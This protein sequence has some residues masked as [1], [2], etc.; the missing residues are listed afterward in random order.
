MASNNYIY[1]MSNAGGMSTLTRYTDMLAGNTTWNPWEPAGAY[2]SVAVATVPSGGV[3]SITFSSI[4]QTYTH[5][6]IRATTRTNRS[7]ANN[8][9][10]FLQFNGDTASNYSW[11]YL[12][13]DGSNATSGAGATQTSIWT[14]LSASALSSA[15][16]FGAQVIDILDYANISKGKTIRNLG[17]VDLNGTSGGAMNLT[18]GNWRSNSSIT[19]ITLFSGFGSSI[20]QHSSFALYGIKG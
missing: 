12:Q 5:L 10:I 8:D 14:W 4:P 11:H 2:E 16:I 3:A 13:G 20:S 15:N 6:Q 7:D 18:S 1:K 9:L 19:S 17:G